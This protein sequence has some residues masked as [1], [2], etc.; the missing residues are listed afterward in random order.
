MPPGEVPSRAELERRLLDEANEDRFGL[1]EACWSLRTDFSLQLSDA[2]VGAQLEPV[3]RDLVHRGWLALYRNRWTRPEYLAVPADQMDRLLADPLN[4][5]V[6]PTA[7]YWAVWFSAT[8]AG[9]QAWRALQ[10][11][12]PADR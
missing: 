4:W 3:I 12:R 10:D 11:Q 5:L 8:E 2:E 1:W 6:P 9:E 7:E